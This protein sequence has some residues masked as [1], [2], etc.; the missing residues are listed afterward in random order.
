MAF[1][2]FKIGKN[3]FRVAELALLPFAATLGQNFE[4]DEGVFFFGLSTALHIGLVKN[5]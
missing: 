3:I 2:N 5:R 1:F 4:Q